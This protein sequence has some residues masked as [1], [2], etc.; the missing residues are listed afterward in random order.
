MNFSFLTIQHLP[1]AT[2]GILI[3]EQAF[4]KLNM[5]NSYVLLTYAY[6]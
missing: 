2:E 3:Q 6:N 4:A 1:R 5:V